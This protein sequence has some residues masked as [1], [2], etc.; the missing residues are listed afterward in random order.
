[1]PRQSIFILIFVFLLTYPNGGN[2]A[3]KEKDLREACYE[4]ADV[5]KFFFLCS[6]KNG[7]PCFAIYNPTPP[8]P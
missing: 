7:G 1:M 2:G 8:P 3:F 4:F 6:L 5:S